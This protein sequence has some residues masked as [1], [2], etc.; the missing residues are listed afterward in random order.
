MPEDNLSAQKLQKDQVTP[1]GMFQFLAGE[2]LHGSV[3]LGVWV[4]GREQL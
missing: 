3:N 1:S 2:K 4:E